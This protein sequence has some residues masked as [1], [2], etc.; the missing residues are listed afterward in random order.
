MKSWLFRK[1][2]NWSGL[3]WKSKKNRSVLSWRSRKIGNVLSWK[4][5]SCVGSFLKLWNWISLM[6]SNRE[7]FVKL[8]FFIRKGYWKSRKLW[9]WNGWKI[10]VLEYVWWLK[11]RFIGWYKRNSC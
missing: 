6:L 4:R 7:N 11:K 10:N 3:L 9:S 1:I 2:W 5:K 8:I